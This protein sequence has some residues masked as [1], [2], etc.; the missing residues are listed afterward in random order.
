M[1]SG[2]YSLDVK[3]KA[4][5]SKVYARADSAMH[6]YYAAASPT[7]IFKEKTI[8][9]AMNPSGVKLRESRDSKEHPNSVG[10]IIAL[11]VTGSMGSVPTFLI[12]E[13][14][15][16]IMGEII[17]AGIKDPQVLFVGIGDHE[18]DHFPLQI[19]QFESSDPLLDKW[20]TTVYLEGGGGGN[21]GESYLLAHYFAARHTSLDCWEKRKQKGVL[22]SIGDE[23]P[24]KKLPKSSLMEIM[25]N[26]NQYDNVTEASALLDEARKTYNVFHILIKETTAGSR[27]DTY[28]Q[29]KQLLGDHCIVAERHEDVAKIIAD[30]VKKNVVLSSGEKLA[31]AGPGVDTHENI[32]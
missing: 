23:P 22:I 2:D 18:C 9:T 13:G 17:Q 12:K 15:P 1:G 31:H 20:L 8:N 24:L 6:A 29:W 16:N 7:E 32:L 25:G 21:E 3:L 26:D 11:D 19:G 14:F 4:D 5:G 27:S 30:I 28:N 10:I